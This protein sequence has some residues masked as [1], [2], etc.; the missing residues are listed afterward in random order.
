MRCL[1]LACGLLLFSVSAVE[2]RL[3]YDVSSNSGSFWV[4]GP[5]GVDLIYR[6]TLD[7]GFS[8]TYVL[9]LPNARVVQT[10][11]PCAPE[12][13][14][15]A[16]QW[17]VSFVDAG[18][19]QTG[20]E[21][22]HRMYSWSD[23]NH[24]IILYRIRNKTSSQISPFVSAEIIPTL[25]GYRQYGGE[26]A[27]F[28]PEH[29]IGFMYEVG[30]FLGL[31]PANVP[32][33]SYRTPAYADFQAAT[34][35]VAFRFAQMSDPQNTPF[36]VTNDDG[37][38]VFENA[39][40]HG[41]AA[42]DSADVYVILGFGTSTEAM[43]GEILGAQAIFDAWG[44]RATPAPQPQHIM[45]RSCTPNPCEHACTLR[46]GVAKPSFVSV[47]VV[48][49][50]GRRVASPFVGF[51]TPGERE[52]VW[53]LRSEAGQREGPGCYVWVVRAGQG[54]VTSPFVVAP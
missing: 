27:D 47:E 32:C 26:T 10:P 13:A 49:L 16:R 29:G 50:S 7:I 40:P 18:G 21:A 6:M 33:Y 24:L 25:E 9:S 39:G 43:V 23:A 5:D 51:C 37:L 48:D 38:L 34:D 8:E 36:P 4:Y 19:N 46:L 44:T 30:K 3:T 45:I 2:A 17:L 15:S 54:V 35:K 28:I 42:G 41:I 14:D 52:V 20:I 12:F 1:M 53:S 22:L 11:A 31:K